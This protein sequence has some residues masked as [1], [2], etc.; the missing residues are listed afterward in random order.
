MPNAIQS[1]NQTR[2]QA[3]KQARDLCEFDFGA[4]AELFPSR[5]KKGRGRI[6]Y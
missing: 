4:P 1:I 5:N 2:E 3:R 6:T